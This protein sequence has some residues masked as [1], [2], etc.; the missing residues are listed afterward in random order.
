MIGLL[1]AL[2]IGAILCTG[3]ASALVRQLRLSPRL[4]RTEGVVVGATDAPGTRPGTRGRAAR[5][6]FTTEDGREVEASS[7]FYFFVGPRPGKRV[8]VTYDP[9]HPERT[10]ER[11]G[12]RLFLLYGHGPLTIAGG[13]A[14]VVFNLV[15]VLE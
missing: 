6:R 12:V 15:K 4:V 13:V 3:G 1:P 8:A 10:A 9:A 2:L 7:A 5:F 11:A 14:I